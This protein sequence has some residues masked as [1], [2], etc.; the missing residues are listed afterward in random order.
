LT[1][2]VW[3][4]DP[5]AEALVGIKPIRCATTPIGDFAARMNCTVDGRRICLRVTWTDNFVRQ[6]ACRRLA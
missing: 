4:S 3:L 5:P 2:G 1:A 6:R